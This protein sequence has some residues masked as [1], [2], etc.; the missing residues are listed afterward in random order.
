MI[1]YLAATT[2]GVFVIGYLIGWDRGVRKTH[3][4]IVASQMT[5][6]KPKNQTPRYTSVTKQLRLV[7]SEDSRE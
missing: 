3:E 6:R 2:V 7:K 4:R 5:Q 1:Y